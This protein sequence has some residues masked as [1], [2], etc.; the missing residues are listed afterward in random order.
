MVVTTRMDVDGEGHWQCWMEGTPVVRACQM[1]T[2]WRFEFW[3][4]LVLGRAGRLDAAHKS[5][6]DWL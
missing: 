6:S 3:L 2:D 1:G 5:D 4:C